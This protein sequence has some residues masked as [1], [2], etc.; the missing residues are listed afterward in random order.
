MKE[1]SECFYEDL[2]KYLENTCISVMI[3]CPLKACA[4]LFKRSDLQNHLSYCPYF[5]IQCETCDTFYSPLDFHDC[6]SFLKI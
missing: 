4:T 3:K 6:K 5:K 1:K 2:I